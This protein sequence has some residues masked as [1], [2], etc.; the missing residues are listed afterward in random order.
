MDAAV[1]DDIL[2]RLQAAH[3]DVQR[4]QRTLQP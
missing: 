2:E 4:L 3:Y 1:Y